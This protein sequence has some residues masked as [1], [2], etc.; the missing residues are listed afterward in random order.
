MTEYDPAPG[1]L[2]ADDVWSLMVAT[3][4]YVGQHAEGME[5][6]DVVVRGGRW[7][8]AVLDEL[9]A[10]NVD[11]E[12]CDLSGVSFA[13][14]HLRHVHFRGCKLNDANFRMVE[15]N[16]VAFDD[17]ALVAADFYAAKLTDA[18]MRRCDLR[19]TDWTKSVLAGVDLR[20]SRLE[21]IRGAGS[22]R[23]VT[24]DSSQVVP[25]AYSL[26]VALE[27]TISDDFDAAPRRA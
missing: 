6:G 15:A 10:F 20:G 12:D 19:A 4:D 7:S 9:R 2:V 21:D 23:G 16:D 25:L 18:R 5:M 22:L 1:E 13:G 3:G 26:A 17:A 11:F 8:G 14:A 27:L 24:I